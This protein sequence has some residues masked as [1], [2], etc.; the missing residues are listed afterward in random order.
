MTDIIW[1]DPPAAARPGRKGHSRAFV[2]ALRAN[3]GN[4]AR[5]GTSKSR[6]NATRLRKLY[7]DIEWVTRRDGDGLF[8]VWARAVS[9]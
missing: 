3:P 1:E 9:A 7:P 2:D 6:G 4:W 8:T 5:F